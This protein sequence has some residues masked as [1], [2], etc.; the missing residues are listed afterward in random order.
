MKYETSFFQ[1]AFPYSYT[2]HCLPLL[3]LFVIV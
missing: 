3:Q 1:L 2:P